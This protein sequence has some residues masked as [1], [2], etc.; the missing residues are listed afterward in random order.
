MLADAAERKDAKHRDALSALQAIAGRAPQASPTC[1][2]GDAVK[3]TASIR[4]AGAIVRSE[5]VAHAARLAAGR[6][7]AAQ[8]VGDIRAVG[9]LAL[10]LV[11]RG[12]VAMCAFEAVVV[13]PI[14]VE[15]KE[16][17][18]YEAGP[19]LS[20]PLVHR[21]PFYALFTGGRPRQATRT[22]GNRAP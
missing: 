5:V 3:S 12:H 6:G 8:T 1:I 10:S 4:D 20:S 19:T 21:I 11:K 2:T 18:G 7:A 13:V 22:V 15:D 9:E 17:V 14:E 16:A